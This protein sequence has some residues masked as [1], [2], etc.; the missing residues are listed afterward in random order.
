MEN[1]SYVVILKFI[2][3]T[4]SLCRNYGVDTTNFV[5]NFPAGFKNKIGFYV[6]MITIP[7][8]IV[9]CEVKCLGKGF[10]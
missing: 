10:D 3:N 6:H 1:Y 2:N 9:S 5:A 8:Y 4:F 7:C